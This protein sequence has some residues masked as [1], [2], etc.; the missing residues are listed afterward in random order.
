M[1]KMREPSPYLDTDKYLYDRIYLA[2]GKYNLMEAP[3]GAQLQ[4]QF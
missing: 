1:K 2:H 3:E 4:V